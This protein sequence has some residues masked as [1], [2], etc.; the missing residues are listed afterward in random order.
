MLSLYFVRHG[1]TDASLNNRFCGRLDPPLNAT[2]LAMAHALAARYGMEGFVEIVSSP[3]LR[4]R[5]TAEPTA[6][7]A[8][9]PLTTDEDL[10]EIAYGEWEGRAESE[11]ATADAERFH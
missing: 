9:L 3:L 8:G 7:L 11:V 1:Q 4:A 2:G 10:V 6:Q 5:Q